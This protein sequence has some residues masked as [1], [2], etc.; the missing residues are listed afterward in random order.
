MSTWRTFSI[1]F[2]LGWFSGT[3]L[4]GA[5]SDAEREFF[6]FK[7]RPI[8]AQECY[9]CHSEATKAKGGL[10]LDTR[11][12]WKKGGDS[13]PAI[14]PGKPD[15]SPLFISITH[16]GED[17]KMPK[18]G[19]Q[20]EP[21]LIE[22]FREW[23]AM[24]APDPREEPP[25][26]EQLSNDTNWEAIRDRRKGWWSFQPIQD[27]EVP[28]VAGVE[29]PVDRFIRTRL[30]E[31]GLTPAGPADPRTLHR[32]LSFALV[33]LPPTVQ[34]AEDFIALWNEDSDRAITAL[35][36]R[37][38]AGSAFGERWARHW[39]DWMRY[40][41]THGSEGDPAIPH[42][43]QYRD[44]LIRAL[45]GD[46]PY[47]QLVREHLAGDL[48]AEPRINEALKL[49][50]SAIG[51]AHYRMVFHGFAPT[52]A[53]DEKV[54][55]TDDQI[56]TVTKAFLGL[57]VSCARCHDH[58]FDAI[59]QA[60]YYAMFG[61]F[62]SSLPA[63]VAVDAP[64][65]LGAQ[66][67]ELSSLKEAIRQEIAAFWID[68]LNGDSPGVKSPAQS[69]NFIRQIAA[70]EDVAAEWNRLRRDFDS[71]TAEV[72]KVRDESRRVWNLSD[73]EEVSAWTRVGEGME[74]AESF[75]AGDFVVGM[76]QAVDQ[77]FPG[78]IYSHRLSTKHR[79][80][81]ASPP[82]LLDGE[83]DLYFNVVGDKSSARFS[84]QHYPRKGTVYPVT[85]LEEG[86]WQWAKHDRID[87]WNGDEIHLE[88]A[89]A[90]E[91]PILV[92]RADR[93]WFGIREA[94]L[95][96]KGSP[97]PA[98]VA[99][100][101]MGAIFA[102]GGERTPRTPEE[103]MGLFEETVR[104]LLVQWRTGG[105]MSDA[106]A[107][108]LEDLRAHHYFPNKTAELPE[109][110]VSLLVGYRD[111]ESMIAEPTRAP[112]IVD[113]PGRDQA[114]YVRGNHKEA[115]EPV[116]R[117]FLEAIDQTLYK[118]EGSGRLELV[119]DFFREDNPFT[120]RVAVNRIWTH[121]FGDGLV[122]T[123]DNFGRLGEEPSHPELLDHLATKFKGGMGW[124]IKALIR[125]I[126][127]SDTFQQ[128]S[129]PV[130]GVAAIDPDNRLLSS[131]PVRRLD[132]EAIRDSLL[133]VSGELDGRTF[134]LPQGESST[135]RAVYLK[136]VRNK[137]NPFLSTFD[138]P[139]PASTVGKRDATNV[140]AQSLTLLNDPFI[141]GR[142]RGAA[143][144]AIAELGADA[145][146]G[147]L[148]EWFFLTA[149][150]RP[151]TDAELNGAR[152][153]LSTLDDQYEEEAGRRDDLEQKLTRIEREKENLLEPVRQRL[154][155][156][157]IAARG[158]D[159][160]VVPDL[161]PVSRW[162]F[163]HGL[164]DLVGELSLSL[165]GSAKVSKG[166]LILDGSGYASTPPLTVDLR[167]KT[168][169]ALVRLD[170]LDQRGGGVITIQDR[171]GTPFDSLVFSE[172]RSRRW[173]A[174]SNRHVRTMDFDAEDEIEAVEEAVRVTLVYE[175][176]GTIRCYRNG[177]R[178]GQSIRKAAL[179]GYEAG[180]AEVLLGLRHGRGVGT[181]RSLKGRIYE[182]ALY[183]R[184][185][186][187]LEVQLSM[188]NK[189]PRVSRE[190]VMNALT[191]E[192]R[193]RLQ[194]VEAGLAEVRAGLSAFS[195]DDQDQSRRWQDL[196][197]AI[198]NLKEF[199]YL[200]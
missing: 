43:W 144:R 4:S 137:L 1:L 7:I 104:R 90:A 171:K 13:G 81:I 59:S 138:F 162:E 197:H 125:E 192:Q 184:A 141:A 24:G 178:W 142:A 124:S 186:S 75:G 82:Q 98:R 79:G 29:K 66:R 88:L 37:L 157:Q 194:S 70:K 160:E 116:P 95:V 113:R 145:D 151:A 48:L 33:G 46:V 44:Y 191:E 35:V 22:D 154:L 175:K 84:V 165:H 89:T 126:V 51:P 15:Q 93:S 120:A 173:L 27:P 118:G 177:E 19:A 28:E 6:E 117:R 21:Q 11:A 146:E 152:S 54:K 164:S 166:A 9:E 179:Q 170:S 150:N 63:T 107:L 85:D 180:S 163:K 80:F 161:A 77:I 110:V 169:E 36:D 100:E 72:K 189:G 78:G 53:L 183:D 139:V 16:E 25:S 23:I 74:E 159:R 34:E 158:G 155:D 26:P 131:F 102:T 109:S 185:L 108:L 101:W 187:P 121:L 83:Y 176:D 132:A 56:N 133:S 8:L 57:T 45:N 97:S 40:A 42:A 38:M 41:E 167:E 130:D 105:G 188:K 12:G 73:A 39:M 119:E 71:R 32:R 103:V 3:S 172:R 193:K 114:L 68:S 190:M 149:L 135:R 99:D 94:V 134:G 123:V 14:V 195:A 111:V 96:K 65:V 136:V 49:N 30:V 147:E 174:G 129:V 18:A 92:K 153:F 60:D 76:S 17:L 64:G 168:L 91:A 115:G 143:L 87:Y 181:N 156:E 127:L 47:D 61:I 58:K 10:L 106:G 20:L 67:E 140:P 198:F 62:A 200:Q 86:K 69:L 128:S 50:E 199:I 2:L 182:A 31:S 55:F 148:I 196:A 52:D 5:M 122:A 112:G